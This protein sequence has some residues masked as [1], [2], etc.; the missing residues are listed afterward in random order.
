[1]KVQTILDLFNVRGYSGCVDPET[2]I[3]LEGKEIGAISYAIPLQGFYTAGELRA[4]LHDLDA[5][6]N[7]EGK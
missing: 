2:P 4:V 6:N 5:F 7:A 1:M 3:Q